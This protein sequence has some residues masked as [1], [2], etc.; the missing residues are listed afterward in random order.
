[1]HADTSSYTYISLYVISHE[2]MEAFSTW[3]SAVISLV[4]NEAAKVE[5]LRLWG[6]AKMG[7]FMNSLYG[8]EG[9]CGTST[10]GNSCGTVLDFLDLLDDFHPLCHG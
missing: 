7:N 9:K 4:K 5:R 10:R 8:Q 6:S 2:I 3:E 1:M